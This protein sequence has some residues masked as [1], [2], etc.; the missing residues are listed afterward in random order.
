VLRGQS[1]PTDFARR[2]DGGIDRREHA[3]RGHLQAYSLF[4]PHRIRVL[5][6]PLLSADFALL[7]AVRPPTAY[8]KK[9]DQNPTEEAEKNHG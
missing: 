3:N 9:F 1:D 8:E 2:S 4:G 5:E 6:W 7:G